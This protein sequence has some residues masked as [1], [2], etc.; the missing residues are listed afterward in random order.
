MRIVMLG[1]AI[2]VFMVL[3]LLTAAFSTIH[4]LT[5]G[6]ERPVVYLLWAIFLAVVRGRVK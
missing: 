5:H 6:W 3:A 2:D 1:K 4:G